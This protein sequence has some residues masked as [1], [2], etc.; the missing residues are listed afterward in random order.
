[1]TYVRMIEDCRGDLIEIE[2][3][4]SAQCFTEGTGEDAYGHRWPCPEQADYS[5]HC[6]TCGDESAPANGCEE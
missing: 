2:H 4:C 3:Y 6:P 5:Q 1:M